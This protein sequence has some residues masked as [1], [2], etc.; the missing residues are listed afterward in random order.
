MAN[1]RR[2][3]LVPA[4]ALALATLVLVA[5]PA[6]AERSF[7]QVELPGYAASFDAAWGLRTATFTTPQG[8]IDVFLPATLGPNDAYTV[9]FRLTPAAGG[10][11]D[12]GRYALS[13]GADR[14]FAADGLLSGRIGDGGESIALRLEGL[15]GSLLASTQVPLLRRALPAPADARF[16]SVGHAGDPLIL[17][18]P[19]DGDLATTS[20]R[21]DGRP[22]TLLAESPR[23]VIAVAPVDRV[24][25]AELR[26]TEN[27]S[28]TKA[29]FRALRIEVDATTDALATGDKG[30]LGV[31]VLGLEGLE[32]EITL[33]SINRTPEVVSIDG[34]ESGLL[35][36]TVRPGEVAE[37]GSFTFDVGLTGREEGDFEVLVAALTE[38]DD[39]IAT[40]TE[41]VTNPPHAPGIT[42]PD[43]VTNETWPP[44]HTPNVTFP[45]HTKNVTWPAGHITNH[46][47]PVHVRNVTIWQ[48]PVETGDEEPVDGETGSG[49][50]AS[51]P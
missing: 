10:A 21:F 49:L 28:E 26:L 4:M 22:L 38:A 14:A 16:P 18:G 37:D 45:P 9:T 29:P 3:H 51:G 24:G 48:Y 27:G 33:L 39:P 6:T 32:Q 41:N 43:H 2:I 8:T 47:W 5:L 25:V 23:D 20:V 17:N 11:A 40:H 46:T 12:L 31:R 19:F 50:K 36:R 13:L 44:Y 7:D 15:D 34:A 1:R 42:S 35:R 30:S